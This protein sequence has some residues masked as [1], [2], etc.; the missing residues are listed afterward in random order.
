M[1]ENC[2]D[3]K[4]LSK[5]PDFR[6]QL[7]VNQSDMTLSLYNLPML[8]TICT[9]R[10]QRCSIADRHIRPIAAAILDESSDIEAIEEANHDLFRMEDRYVLPPKYYSSRMVAASA[11]S[12]DPAEI[13]EIAENRYRPPSERCFFAVQSRCN[14][15]WNREAWKR[16]WTSRCLK[17][18]GR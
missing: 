14:V 3:R 6:L 1:P 16:V 4:L 13:L 5:R 18:T 9:T 15:C 10:S 11:Q 12:K 7:S 2:D 8:I 17:V